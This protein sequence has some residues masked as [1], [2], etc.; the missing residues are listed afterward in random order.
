MAMPMRAHR[1]VQ[2]LS[3]ML[4]AKFGIA[5]MPPPRTVA[6]LLKPSAKSSLRLSSV[7]CGR[8]T[9]SA[10]TRWPPTLMNAMRAA[11]GTK[12]TSWPTLRIR[13]CG[14]N[15]GSR[16]WGTNWMAGSSQMWYASA[17]AASTSSPEAVPA[18]CVARRAQTLQQR[19]A[20]AQNGTAF[21]TVSAAGTLLARLLLLDAPLWGAP[22]TVGRMPKS[23]RPPADEDPGEVSSAALPAADAHAPRRRK[24]SSIAINPSEIKHVDRCAVGTYMARWANC[25]TGMAL[26]AA[27][28]VR[29][30]SAR[31]C[32]AR[33]MRAAE[34]VRPLSSGWEK[35]SVIEAKSRAPSRRCIAPTMRARTLAI[36]SGVMSKA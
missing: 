12:G 17:P 21:V 31:N 16:I 11:T 20:P 27:G 7:S 25:T 24:S 14:P 10:V 34:K 22:N 23:S 3:A 32:E 26:E 13:T 18:A 5:G 2:F 9:R 15:R 30:A 8:R 33:T 29:P 1:P 4:A 28:T 19:S 36:S 35:S 6:K